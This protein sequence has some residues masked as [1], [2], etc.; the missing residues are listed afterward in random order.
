[1]PV[2]IAQLAQVPVLYDLN[3]AEL[4]QL[5]S[6]ATIRTYQARETVMREGDQL[7]HQLYV[8]LTGI[9]QITRL[10]PQ[11]R[12]TVFRVLPAGE[13]FA[14]PALIGN[15]IAPAT[16]VATVTAEVLTIDRDALLQAISRK[17]EIVLRI[18]AVY[19]QRLQQL[20]NTVHDLISERAIV[21][22]VRLIQYYADRFGTTTVNQVAQ[23]QTKQEQIKQEQTEQL[24]VKLSYYQLARSVGI[25]YEECVRLF[26]LLHPAAAYK[27]GGVIQIANWQ[28]LAALVD[29]EASQ[30]NR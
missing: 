23:E 3:E 30:S 10:S 11:G 7:P 16:V 25:T 1:M 26:K 24:N 2:S 18:L 22:L 17:P 6:F 8:V 27:R 20:H 12:E 9:L 14:A 19:N 29:R 21:R 28:S 13:I 15:G 5:Q 4:Q